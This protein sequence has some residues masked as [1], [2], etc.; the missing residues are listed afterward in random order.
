M[1]EHPS[2]SGL[3]R[4]VSLQL[5]KVQDQSCVELLLA[6]SRQIGSVFVAE[7]QISSISTRMAIRTVVK[8]ASTIT[9]GTLTG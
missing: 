4:A 9:V 8:D 6:A 2:G 5:N 1:T 7:I 3:G